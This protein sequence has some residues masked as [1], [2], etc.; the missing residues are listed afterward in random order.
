MAIPVQ[1]QTTH[2]VGA[3]IEDIAMSMRSEDFAHIASVLNN[4]YSDPIAAVVR[5]YSTNA[6]DS[7]IMAGSDRPIEVTLPSPERMEFSV[8]D[9]GMGLS[10]DDLRNVY[11]MYGASNKRH[12]N[13]VA[14]MLGLGSKSGLSYAEAF[15]IVAIKGGV[16]VIAMSTKDEHGVGVIKVLDT[17]GTDEPNGVKITIPVQRYDTQDFIDAATNIFQ[18]WEP[19]TVLIDGIAPEVPEWRATA[20]SLDA[21][22]HTFLVRKDSGLCRSYVIMGNVG[23]PVPDAEVG[24]NTFRFVARLNISDVSI[25]P[26]R[27]EVQFTPHTKATLSGLTEYIAATYKRAIATQL[28]TA[29]TRWEET[30]LK[31]LW[32]D[33]NVSLRSPSGTPIWYYDPSGYH[34]QAHANTSYRIDGL[35]Q[36][37]LVVIT[38]FPAK[39]LSPAAR[40]RLKG[41]VRDN[42]IAHNGFVVI[43][44]GVATGMLDGRPNTF[45]WDTILG[46]TEAPAKAQRAKQKKVETVY[47]TSAGGM[48]GA[49]LAQVKGKV[50]YVNTN[51]RYSH[52]DLGATVIFMQSSNQMARIL[53]FVP[54]AKPYHEGVE[55]A[56]AKAKAALTDR[57]AAIVTARTLPEVFASF[58][59]DDVLDTELAEAIRLRSAADTATMQ[60]AAAFGVYPE[61]GKSL[62]DKFRKRYPLLGAIEYHTYKVTHDKAALADALLYVN[63]KFD[64]LTTPEAVAS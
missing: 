24:R 57:D 42:S 19:G 30:I 8:Q 47:S 62:S 35:V 51:M 58:K 49:Q 29:A 36:P 13:D 32:M 56:K 64:A 21:W 45:T 38:G 20:L 22:D 43:P 52:G 10:I 50:Y 15:T 33:R 6:L 1:I 34:R 31:T 18:F 53:R 9:F 48:T 14:G 40:D 61:R 60:A 27:E 37:S 25:P 26:S 46:A 17:V 11:A 23:Y 63:N 3:V 39:N 5:E 4:L 54:K 7:H 44:E 55:A 41:F 12:T 2:H 16:K 28:A 59:P